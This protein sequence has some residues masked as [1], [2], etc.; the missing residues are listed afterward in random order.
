MQLLQRAIVLDQHQPE[1]ASASEIRADC[2]REDF[3]NF[4]MQLVF[5]VF[6]ECLEE[7]L[8]SSRERLGRRLERGGLRRDLGFVSP[9]ELVLL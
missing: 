3:Q 6:I 9:M 2:L 5:L 7:E 4:F 1:S 8:N